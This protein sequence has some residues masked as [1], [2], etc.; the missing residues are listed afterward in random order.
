MFFLPKKY[1]DL[2]I[3]DVV[4]IQEIVTL[5]YKFGF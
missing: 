5:Q 3:T 1:N 2:P 4:E